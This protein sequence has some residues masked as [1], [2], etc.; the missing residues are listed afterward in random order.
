MIDVEGVKF[1]HFV[2]IS[3]G[4][5]ATPLMSTASDLLHD[6]ARGRDVRCVDHA[7]F[8]SSPY[9][10]DVNP[11]LI[12]LHGLSPPPPPPPISC[13]R[14]RVGVCDMI[15]SRI[16]TCSLRLIILTVRLSSRFGTCRYIRFVWSCKKIESLESLFFSDDSKNSALGVAMEVESIERSG[17]GTSPP[18]SQSP[19]L[20]RHVNGD[21]VNKQS[22]DRV[23]SKELTDFERKGAPQ[24]LFRST[25]HITR[26]QVCETHISLFIPSLRCTSH[27]WAA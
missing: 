1:K 20:P 23:S 22:P 12:A 11:A 18:F 15:I 7:F 21:H 5:G 24:P 3:G 6:A 8:P 19:K 16:R 2:L 25:L 9:A 26:D 13:T 27:M 17:G 10:H 14:L 4:A